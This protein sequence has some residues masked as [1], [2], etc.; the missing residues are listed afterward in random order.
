MSGPVHAQTTGQGRIYK[1]PDSGESWPSVTTI[2]GQAVNKPALPRW[3]AKASAE[4]AAG[5]WDVLASLE[6]DERVTL[7]KGA[8]WKLSDKAAN[9]G[10]AVHDAVDHWLRDEPMPEWAPGVEPFMVQ[11]CEFLEERKPRIIYTETTVINREVGYAG[12]LDILAEI[13]GRITLIDTKTGKGVYPEAGL[14]LAALAHAETV[15]HPNGSEEDVCPPDVAAVLH[16]RPR[17][18]ALVPITDLDACWDGFRYA[19]GVAEWVRDTAPHVLGP[20]LKAVKETPK[21]TPVYTGWCVNGCGHEYGMHGKNG[22]SGLVTGWVGDGTADF[23][24]GCK[25]YQDEQPTEAAHT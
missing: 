13:N 12:T 20:R 10:T 24:C 14:Q 4:Y 17:S 8:P 1:H 18:W 25:V 5:N 6:E 3:A 16:L 22:C 2:I 19:V 11:L 7:I 21:R 23:P 9:L 15:L